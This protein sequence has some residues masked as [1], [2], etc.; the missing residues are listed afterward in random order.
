MSHFTCRRWNV[1]CL[2]VIFVLSSVVGSWFS[3]I[4]VA[5][6][7]TESG[8]TIP[9]AAANQIFLP[10]VRSRLPLA[11]WPKCAA[12]LHDPI[13]WHSLINEEH[14]C[15]Y[16]HEHKDDPH[17]VNDI[18]GPAGAY[19]GGQEISYPWLTGNGTE[20]LMW[21]NGKHQGYGWLVHRNIGNPMN[22]AYYIDAFRGQYHSIMSATDAVVRFHSYWLEIKVCEEGAGE[23]GILRTGGWSDYNV[24][25]I[26]DKHVPLHGDGSLHSFTRRRDYRSPARGNEQ[27]DS[28]WYGGANSG[29][30]AFFGLNGETWGLVSQNDPHA[31][32]LFCPDFR[33]KLNGSK[34]NPHVVS[35]HLSS[36]WD[37]L[38][39]IKDGKL[40]YTGYTDR[41]GQLAPNCTAPALDCV[42]LILKNVPVNVHVHYRA[43]THD[44]PEVD[45]DISPEGAYWIEY[46]N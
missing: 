35:F 24:L 2:L 7:S 3:E 37:E 43:D 45:Y 17:T 36:D 8:N 34:M 5:S 27:F 4:A 9:P 18:F 11:L 39:G 1:A 6:R 44:Y 23:C 21:P 14:G 40:T 12:E 16:N 31:L 22:S 19:Y 13:K 28:A 26:D 20:N 30:F 33:C 25:T 29:T 46:P 38:D 10:S 15:H 41:Y 42:P 32:H